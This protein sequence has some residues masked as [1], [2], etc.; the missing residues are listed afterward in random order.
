MRLISEKYAEAL[1]SAAVDVGCVG[2]V[3]GDLHWIKPIAEDYSLYFRNPRF[4]ASEKASLVR[5]LLSEHAD[6]V[7]MEF[8]L[9]ILK[10]GH[11]RHLP[12]AI[13]R[14]QIL[15]DSYYH[16]IAVE[17]HVPFEPEQE[18]LYKLERRFRNKGLIPADAVEVKFSIIEDKSIIGGFIAF[19]NGNQIDASLRTRLARVRRAER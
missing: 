18:M 2:E 14:Y 5:E 11:W 3:A 1:F 4:S 9:L 15:S 17:L 7:T 8:I 16:N 19:C 12:D 13:D 6:A 10:R